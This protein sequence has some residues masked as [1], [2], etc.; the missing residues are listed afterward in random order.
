MTGK[1]RP[2]EKNQIDAMPSNEKNEL[3]F[4]RFMQQEM[5]AG[6]ALC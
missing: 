2:I 3:L 4:T 6:R 1:K 5:E